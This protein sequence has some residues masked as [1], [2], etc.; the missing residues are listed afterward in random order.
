M[1]ASLS[2]FAKIAYVENIVAVVMMSINLSSRKS[3][4]F[5][6]NVSWLTWFDKLLWTL[7]N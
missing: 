7:E 3:L 1:V 5:L 6:A 2:A 4:L